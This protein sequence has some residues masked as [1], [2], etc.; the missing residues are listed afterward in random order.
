MFEMSHE[1]RE[2]GAQ[3]AGTQIYYGA[4]V[5]FELT[6]YGESNCNDPVHEKDCHDGDRD[7]EEHC[8]EH[9]GESDEF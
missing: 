2:P 4:M 3:N 9:S 8:I 7:G 6:P 1:N 5:E